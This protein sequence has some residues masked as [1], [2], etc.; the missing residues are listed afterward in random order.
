MPAS[1]LT[2]AAI[3]FAAASDRVTLVSVMLSS[4]RG[5]DPERTNGPSDFQTA[6][7]NSLYHESTAGDSY[8]FMVEPCAILLFVFGI[9]MKAARRRQWAGA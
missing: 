1:A 3:R 8:G 6:D 9:G 4:C 2:I 5:Q 7:I